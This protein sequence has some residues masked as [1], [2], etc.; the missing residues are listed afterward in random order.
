MCSCPR[1]RSP[2]LHTRLAPEE[3]ATVDNIISVVYQCNVSHVGTRTILS[4]EAE[5]METWHWVAVQVLHSAGIAQNIAA[6]LGNFWGTCRVL[7][8]WTMDTSLTSKVSRL[9]GAATAVA[10]LRLHLPLGRVLA[11]SHLGHQEQQAQLLEP[12]A[13]AFRHGPAK[14]DYFTHLHLNSAF[15]ILILMMMYIRLFFWVY[16]D[17]SEEAGGPAAAPTSGV[18]E[19][20]GRGAQ[21]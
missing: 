21:E 10:S 2:G 12:H 15:L 19:A 20:Q 9:P 14:K 18:S 17:Q 11:P 8:T 1:F 3:V 16:L 7:A 13:S 6:I 4:P 5:D